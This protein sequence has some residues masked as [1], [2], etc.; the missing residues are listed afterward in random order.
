MPEFRLAE[1]AICPLDEVAEPG[2]WVRHCV[3]QEGEQF[4]RERAIERRVLRVEP[5]PHEPFADQIRLDPVELD[6]R[7]VEQLKRTSSTD[8]I[9]ERWE[10]ARARLE[11]P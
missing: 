5:E 2:R 7:F 9:I 6:F 10:E 1:V 4:G 11:R 8:R 3:E